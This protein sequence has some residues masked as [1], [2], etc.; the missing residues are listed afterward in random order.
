M[1]G[2][3]WRRIAGRLRAAEDGGVAIEF[4]IVSVALVLVSLGTLEF[5]RALQV[6]NQLAYLADIA[7]R[8]ILKDGEA[9]GEAVEAKLREE[10]QA[11]SPELLQVQID[12][13]DAEG[14]RTVS[15]SYPFTLMIPQL[16]SDAIM[17]STT[18][19]VPVT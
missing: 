7:A 17:L 9:D 1:Q 19:R 2:L 16:S 11:S 15:L 8:E 12:A 14:F 3:S 13:A 5:G 4:A 10:F 18:E 6:R